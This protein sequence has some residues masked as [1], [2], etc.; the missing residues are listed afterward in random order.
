MLCYV[1]TVDTGVC[2]HCR[3]EDQSMQCNECYAMSRLLI[4]V[5][6]ALTQHLIQSTMRCENSTL[7]KVAS[8]PCQE[9]VHPVFGMFYPKQREFMSTLFEMCVF[10]IVQQQ[11]HFMSTL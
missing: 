6:V 2:R 7:Y 9:E 10:P 4:L 11:Y 1:E 5:F 3:N 8:R